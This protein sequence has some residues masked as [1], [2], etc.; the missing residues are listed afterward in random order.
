MGPSLVAKHCLYIRPLRG[1]HFV[2]E[3]RTETARDIREL[4]HNAV[5]H[6][7]YRLG[8]EHAA[9]RRVVVGEGV[10]LFRH[11]GAHLRTLFAQV[12]LAVRTEHALRERLADFVWRDAHLRVDA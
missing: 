3:S 8:L 9:Q 10:D 12:L 6:Q 1:Y 7:H 4:F 2:A 5:A 11:L